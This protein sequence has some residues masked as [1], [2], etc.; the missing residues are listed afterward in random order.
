MF[1]T[2]WFY[3]A[4]TYEIDSRNLSCQIMKEPFSFDIGRENNNLANIEVNGHSVFGL[5][6]FLLKILNRYVSSVMI[7]IFLQLQ[8][9]YIYFKA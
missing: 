3:L 4:E 6:S 2:L 8:S 1:K 9:S 7:Y 5:P